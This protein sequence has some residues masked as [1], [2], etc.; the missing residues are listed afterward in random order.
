M[1]IKAQISRLKENWLLVALVLLAVFFVSGL[2]SSLNASMQKNL[3]FATLGMSEQ[4]SRGIFPETGFAPEVEIRKI[5]K[6]ASL[7][8]EVKRG[9]FRDSEKDLR[10]IVS[11]ADGLILNE[12]VGTSGSGVDSRLYG[13][14][15][16]R[17]PSENYDAVVQEIKKLGEVKTFSENTQDITGSYTTARINLESEQ[18]RLESFKRMVESATEVADKIQLTDRIFDQ[19]RQIK[20]LEEQLS[21]DDER[22]D[23]TSIFVTLQEKASGFAGIVLIRFS[24]I[25]KGLVNSFNSL[26]MLVTVALPYAVALVILRVVYVWHKKKSRF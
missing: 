10:D 22:I 24:E 19:E 18:R 13:S 26:V 7:T 14:Y 9:K 6:S 15:S 12:N 4:F 8:A 17:I 20:F 25:V 3:E 21:T 1:S 5:V 16:L 11:D 2:P 23:Y